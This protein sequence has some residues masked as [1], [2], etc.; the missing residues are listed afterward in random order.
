MLSLILCGVQSGSASAQGSGP[1]TKA[2][3]VER[4]S[5]ITIQELNQ[6]QTLRQFAALDS[7]FTYSVFREVW[8]RLN[9]TSIRT[10]LV[11]SF[12]IGNGRVNGVEAPA[13][14]PNPH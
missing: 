3:W 11:E 1:A 2:E 4:L 10:A 13:Y 8:P 5:H 9:N 6:H 14:Q 7:E 12:L